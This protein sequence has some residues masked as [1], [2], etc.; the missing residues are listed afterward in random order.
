MPGWRRIKYSFRLSLL[1]ESF[2]HDY[3]HTFPVSLKLRAPGP[4]R[5]R[6]SLSSRRSVIEIEELLYP[7][8]HTPASSVYRLQACD[9]HCK[10]WS[11]VAG[12]SMVVFRVELLGIARP[13]PKNPVTLQQGHPRIT[14]PVRFKCHHICKVPMLICQTLHTGL[15]IRIRFTRFSG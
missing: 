12:E 6:Q 5:L 1:S 4:R 10:Q 9:H 14:S 15:A 2:C 13:P 11:Y 7:Q 8:Q 3:C